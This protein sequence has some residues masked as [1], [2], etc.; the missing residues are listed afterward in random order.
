V[1]G[2]AQE[3]TLTS[4][5]A[6]GEREPRS[7]H[8]GRIIKIEEKPN[9]YAK[10][11]KVGTY[12]GETASSSSLNLEHEMMGKGLEKR[13]EE[14]WQFDDWSHLVGFLESKNDKLPRASDSKDGDETK[15][16]C[17]TGPLGPEPS[18]EAN[19]ETQKHE[20]G[21]RVVKVPV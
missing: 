7:Q 11:K 17:L 10:K 5:K 12:E 14:M 18:S 8:T 2:N 3:H 9:P 21:A 6:G 20:G 15:K 19:A 13:K 4:K 16:A 1:V